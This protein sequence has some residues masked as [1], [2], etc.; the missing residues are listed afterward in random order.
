[1]LSIIS[2]TYIEFA[3]DNVPVGPDDL[4]ARTLLELFDFFHL[5]APNLIPLVLHV[6]LEED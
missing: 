3:A 1:M 4:V 6:L 2:N 5:N